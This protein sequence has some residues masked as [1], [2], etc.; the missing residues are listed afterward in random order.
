MRHPL[1]FKLFLRPPFALPLRKL[2][3]EDTFSPRSAR[4][5]LA[6]LAEPNGEWQAPLDEVKKASCWP[7]CVVLVNQKPN[8]GRSW[9]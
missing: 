1:P 9:A 8:D 7:F 2:E 3:E 6:I 4:S 5:L